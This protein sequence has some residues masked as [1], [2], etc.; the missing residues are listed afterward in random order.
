MRKEKKKAAGINALAQRYRH[1]FKDLRSRHGSVRRSAQRL[2]AL[3]ICLPLILV[4]LGYIV[5][6]EWN[7][8]KILRDNAAFSALYDLASLAPA[9]ATPRAA[10][11]E[12]PMGTGSATISAATAPAATPSPSPSAAPTP[13]VTPTRFAVAVDATREPLAT[14]DADTLI[15][16]LETPRPVQQSFGDLLALN[17]ETIGFLT[18]EDVVSLPVV[19]RKNDNQYYLSHSFNGEESLAGTL[20]LDGSNLLT[21][22]DEVLIIYG[23]NMRNG[24]MFHSLVAYEEAAFLGAHPLVRFDT[25]YENR[26]YLPFA[27]LSVTADADSERYLNLRQFGFDDE[28][29]SAYIDG[30]RQLSLWDVPVEVVRG[31]RILLL[32]TCEY[33]HDNGRFVVA[34]RALRPGEDAQEAAARVQNAKAN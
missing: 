1:L 10:A 8:R 18:V 31:D 16:G 34:L 29:F 20:F 17:P 26:L 11:S 32:V 5:R 2:L 19:Q 23:H 30:L 27:A 15:Y 22:E 28:S 12:S 9:T 24:T 4:S 13:E 3:S 33:A 6:W 25:I 21:P 14:P 7:R